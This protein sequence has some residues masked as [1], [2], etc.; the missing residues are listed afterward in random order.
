MRYLKEI[1]QESRQEYTRHLPLSAIEAAP[2]ASA[3]V[4]QG[5]YGFHDKD[6]FVQRTANRGF[7]VFVFT[8]SGKGRMVL[9]DGSEFILSKGDLVVSWS[10]GQGHFEEC[11]SDEPWEHLWI[12]FWDTSPY[13]TSNGKD[14]DIME[15][16]GRDMILSDLFQKICDE[17]VFSDEM[18]SDAIGAYETV[19]LITMN[20][21]LNF[22]DNSLK[23]RQRRDLSALWARV[24]ANTELGWS[25]ADLCDAVGYSKAHL[26]R[27]CKEL[28]GKAPSE[29][30]R[31]LK[32]NHAKVLLHN[33]DLSIA[34][35]GRAIGYDSP[36]VFSAAFHEHLGLSP[37]NFRKEGSQRSGRR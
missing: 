16:S 10:S 3:R 22:T 15:F 4:K 24:E 19:F 20:R 13:F 9:E 30:V 21:I 34:E 11:D 14:Y 32:M 31:E 18:S 29:K 7:H 26:T 35:I 28:Y 5:G 37:R 36:A 33:T 17:D 23:S 1:V 27:H 6:F 12:T 25:V 8:F 2:F